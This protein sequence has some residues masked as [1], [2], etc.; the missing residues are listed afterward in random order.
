MA[1]GARSYS[2]DA[3]TARHPRGSSASRGAPEADSSGGRA[4]VTMSSVR[5]STMNFIGG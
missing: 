2:L 3:Y 5:L 1:S 4:A